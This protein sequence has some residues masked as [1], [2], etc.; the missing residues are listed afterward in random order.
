[1]AG[2]GREPVELIYLRV[3]RGTDKNY[4]NPQASS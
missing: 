2:S 1:V 3:L 4:E